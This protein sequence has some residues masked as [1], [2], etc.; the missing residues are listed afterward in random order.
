[1]DTKQCFK[2]DEVKAIEDFY[3]H[4]AMADGRLNKCIKCA[5]N[6]ER[7][8]YFM[9]M[10]DPEWAAAEA[11]R[12]R[13]RNRALNYSSKV[14]SIARRAVRKLGRSRDY[15]WHHWSYNK[16]HH[17]D[18][19]KLTPI[20]H[21]KLHRFLEFDDKSMMYR[22]SDTKELLDTRPKHEAFADYIIKTK[23]D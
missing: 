14:V 21:R 11:E 5:R 6:D 10:K 17:V 18:C 12:N 20:Q 15:H 23:E 8:R 19:L 3:P 7:E 13:V 4:K 2:C 9:K 16:E 22:R 1:M